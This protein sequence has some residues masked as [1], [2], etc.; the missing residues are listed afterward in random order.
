[1]LSK[2][3]NK[4]QIITISASFEAYF[5]SSGV[6]LI[7]IGM[8]RTLRFLVKGYLLVEQLELEGFSGRAACEK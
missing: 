7:L 6:K 3:I 4:L 5:I 2:S 8:G 1:M